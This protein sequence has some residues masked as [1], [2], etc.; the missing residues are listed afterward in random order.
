MGTLPEKICAI[1]W[2]AEKEVL[3]D[4]EIGGAEDQAEGE[5]EEAD[6]TEDAEMRVAAVTSVLKVDVAQ[7]CEIVNQ[8]LDNLVTSV[9]KVD[10]AQACEIV[11]QCLDNLEKYDEQVSELLSTEEVQGAMSKDEWQ[12]SE[13]HLL[14]AKVV[15]T[16]HAYLA[17]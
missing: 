11:N 2:P 4:P 6:E 14:S 16:Q 12:Q 8:C 3:G 9:L 15:P 17:R 13:Q 7:A 10:V 1:L 5:E